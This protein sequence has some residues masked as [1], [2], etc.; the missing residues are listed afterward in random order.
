MKRNEMLHKISEE[1]G[2]APEQ[3][4]QVYLSLVHTMSDTLSH[5]EEIVLIPELGIFAPRLW[6]NPGRNENSQRTRLE[7][8]YK[9]RFRPG[10]EMEKML[11][12]PQEDG[13]GAE[14]GAE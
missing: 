8:R 10:K 9:I 5:G 12:L 13:Y 2:L 4:E 1:T 11:R 3:V 14:N 6:N 7:A